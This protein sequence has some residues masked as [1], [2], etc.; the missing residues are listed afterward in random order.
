MILRIFQEIVKCTNLILSFTFA[1]CIKFSPTCSLCV[2][3]SLTNIGNAFC[4]VIKLTSMLYL[5]A[6][7]FCAFS[8]ISILGKEDWNYWT[9][10]VRLKYFTRKKTSRGFDKVKLIMLLQQWRHFCILLISKPC[11]SLKSEI[12]ISVFKNMKL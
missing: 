8:K 5:S 10:E 2:Y 12:Y 9:Y 11:F 6:F 7:E 4:Y 3:L 1:C